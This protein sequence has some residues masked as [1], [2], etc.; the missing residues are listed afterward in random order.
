MRRHSAITVAA[1]VLLTACGSSKSAEKEHP[2]TSDEA[3]RLAGVQV[4]NHQALGAA[5]E[6]NTT[7]T[8]TGDTLYMAGDIDWVNHAGHAMVSAKGAEAATTEIIWGPQVVIERR[9]HLDTILTEMGMPNAKFIVRK[10]DPA[11]RQIDRAIAILTGLSAE[12]PENA[13]LIQQKQGSAFMRSDVW[14]GKPVEVLR[15]GTQN[16]YWVET[17]TSVLRRFDG[18]AQNGTAPIVIDFISFGKKSIP[19]PKK[20]YVVA[21]DDVQGVYNSSVDQ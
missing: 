12:Q 10:P 4:A 5:F 7:F 18:N 17:G 13:L 14:R 20:Q 16:R 8:T 19:L 3:A 21:F 9:P 2:L 6:V 15:F 1:I 11:R